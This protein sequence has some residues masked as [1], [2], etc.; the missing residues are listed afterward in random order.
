[1]TFT[2]INVHI[3]DTKVLPSFK[4]FC[5]EEQIEDQRKRKEKE[6]EKKVDWW[7]LRK[8]PVTEFKVYK[9]S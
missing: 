8:S 9:F 6:K 5:T 2:F 3:I 7:E 1:M 4:S